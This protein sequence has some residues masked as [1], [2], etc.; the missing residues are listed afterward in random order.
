MSDRFTNTEEKFKGIQ[1]QIDDT[2]NCILRKGHLCGI[3]TAVSFQKGKEEDKE[4]EDKFVSEARAKLYDLLV[5][6][7]D[8]QIDKCIEYFDANNV[9]F[10]HDLYNSPYAWEPQKQ[11]DV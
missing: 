9:K 6:I 2:L 5:S 10:G 4:Q 8:K 1:H 7:Q 11:E 3:D